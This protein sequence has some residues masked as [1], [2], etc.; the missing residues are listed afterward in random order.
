MGISAKNKDRVGAVADI[1]GSVISGNEKAGAANRNAQVDAAIEQE[2]I[3]A[4][5]DESFQRQLMTRAQ[6]DRAAQTNAWKQLQQTSYVANRNSQPQTSFS[7][8]TRQLA[9]VSDDVVAGAKSLMD[10]QRDALMA[11][12]YNTNGGAPLPMPTRRAEGNGTPFTIDPKLTK[13]PGGFWRT[14]A[15]YALPAAETAIQF[16]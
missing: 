13:E 10:T 9:P 11:G 2:K 3:R 7:P 6:D 16:I 4:A 12:R 15:K 5:E 8:Y 1:W 14:L